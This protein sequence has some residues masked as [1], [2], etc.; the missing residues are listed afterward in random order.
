MVYSTAADF[1]PYKGND[2]TVPSD[3]RQGFPQEALDKFKAG[4]L[5]P[6]LF[7]YLPTGCAVR[8]SPYWGRQFLQV[9]SNDRM[10]RSTFT[11]DPFLSRVITTPVYGRYKADGMYSGV[12]ADRDDLTKFDSI[13]SRCKPSAFLINFLWTS[14]MLDSW[15]ADLDKDCKAAIKKEWSYT[16]SYC[17]G[18]ESPPWGPD[19]NGNK[20]ESS[21]VQTNGVSHAFS[22]KA[23]L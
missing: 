1:Q 13:P 6:T 9:L 23:A 5:D 19:I 18:A 12:W 3:D 16:C 11:A 15:I 21:G 8:N 14:Q 22:T 7:K 20:P 17:S 10:E 4:N 2:P